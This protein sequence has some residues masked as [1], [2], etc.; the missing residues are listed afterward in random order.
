M[1]RCAHVIG[2]PGGEAVA[3]GGIGY[4]PGVEV[5]RGGCVGPR[6][7]G[8]LVGPGVGVPGLGVGVQLGV[9]EGVPGP[10]V[11]V[12]DGVAVGI[13]VPEVGLDV[14]VGVPMVVTASVGVAVGTM[15]VAD[16]EIT[17][18]GVA[19]LSDGRVPGGVGLPTPGG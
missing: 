10:I 17:I 7:G 4:A 3:V 6:V 1:E 11:N 15:L 18:V 2:Y 5:E 8:G 12:G 13:D 19:V 14:G 9:T 16:G